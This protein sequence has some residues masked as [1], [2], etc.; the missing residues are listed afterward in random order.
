MCLVSLNK[1]AQ[2]LSFRKL[3][4]KITDSFTTT[5][6]D[7]DQQNFAA[8]AP[9]EPAT[10]SH[11]GTAHYEVMRVEGVHQHRGKKLGKETTRSKLLDMY[12]QKKTDPNK[13][14]RMP[15]VIDPRTNRSIAYWDSI[16]SLALIFTAFVTPF[17]VGFLSPVPPDERFSNV[18]FLVNRAVDIVFLIDMLLQ[19]CMG[20]EE[21]NVI[22]RSGKRWV[23]NARD[24]VLHYLTSWWFLLDLLAI[25]TSVLD[26]T[27]GGG[28]DNG[29]DLFALRS[30]RALRL[31]K[32][33]R[34]LRGSRM[35]LRWEK[36]MNINYA[37]LGLAQ[38]F[39][40]ILTAIHWFA[41]IWG[42]QASFNPL[43][44]WLGTLG[45]CTPLCF[46]EDSGSG[47]QDAGSACTVS[48]VEARALL[49]SCPSNMR[50]DF[51]SCN[52][53]EC[54]DGTICKGA[55]ESYIISVYFATVTITSVGYG[56]VSASRH[57]SVE[58]I[59]A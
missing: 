37:Y 3:K 44:T 15:W 25:A 38:T 14:T 35:L 45:Y 34:L 28:G 29:G 9:S 13:A 18:L 32:L 51:Q 42:L 21:E 39:V 1:K 59:S 33:I 6:T 27:G 16:A 43:G 24:I 19:F 55:F 36:R 40:S 47:V 11:P 22:E 2:L 23:F 58:Q 7:R 56:D 31:F 54:S 10:L 41:C 20:Y 50:C 8:A 30:L 57:N 26:I 52:A 53:L 12:H 46:E 5:G 49:A 17:E 48:P 4:P